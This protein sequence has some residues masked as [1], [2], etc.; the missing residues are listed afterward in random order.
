MLCDT[1]TEVKFE[2]I[3]LFLSIMG[4]L[5]VLVHN[6]HADCEVHTSTYH[7]EF[8]RGFFWHTRVLIAI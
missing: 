1:M 4:Y 5:Q 8:S 3:T 6:F 7:I 2:P